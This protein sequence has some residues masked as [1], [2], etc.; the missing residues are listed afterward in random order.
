MGTEDHYFG[1]IFRIEAA[2]PPS[3]A[4]W[5][6]SAAKARDRGLGVSIPE[7]KIEQKMLAMEGRQG[8]R[9]EK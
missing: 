6:T 8:D 3:P 2:P 9:Y 5:I 1:P 4:K 7:M